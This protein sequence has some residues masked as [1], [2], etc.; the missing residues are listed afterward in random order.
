MFDKDQISI[1]KEAVDKENAKTQ[2]K[3]QKRPERKIDFT[4]GSGAPVNRYY[5]PV[6]IADFDYM[7]DLGL[8]GQYPYTR[9]VQPTMYRGQFWTMRM[10]AGFATADED[11]KSVV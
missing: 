2:E 9:G 5:T 11:R 1:L 6:D 10:Y 3:L 4:T 8:P 7:D